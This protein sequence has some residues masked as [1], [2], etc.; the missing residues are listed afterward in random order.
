TMYA[1]VLFPLLQVSHT[2]LAKAK[3][4]DRTDT[5]THDFITRLVFLIF[6]AVFVKSRRDIT[7]VFL[8]FMIS[9]YAAVPSALWNWHQGTLSLGFRAV[10]S[11]TLGANPNKLAMICLME[12]ACWWFWSQSKPGL[13]RR[14]AAYVALSTSLFV[15]L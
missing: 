13:A 2:Q 10:S 5:M 4:L 6:M 1:D 14:G 12:I 11:V 9:L 3:S 8:T 15:L 7:V